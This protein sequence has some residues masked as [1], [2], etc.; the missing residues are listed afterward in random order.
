MWLIYERWVTM[1]DW[2]VCPACAS[3]AGRVFVRGD[4]PHPPLHP[5]CRCRRVEHARHWRPDLAPVPIGPQVVGPDPG[6]GD[7]ERKRGKE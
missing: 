4:G 2:D 7:E 1:D 3:L 6:A 5:Y